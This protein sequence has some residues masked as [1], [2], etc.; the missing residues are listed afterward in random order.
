MTGRRGEERRSGEEERRRR[1]GRR[2]KEEGKRKGEER[3]RG[4]ERRSGEGS[5]GKEEW[6]GVERRGTGC[7]KHIIKEE[8]RE[9][10][11]IHVHSNDNL[12]QQTWTLMPGQ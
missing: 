3:R 9:M 1:Q 6:R 12:N 11:T 4:E 7:V 8:K 2:G 10:E 5:R